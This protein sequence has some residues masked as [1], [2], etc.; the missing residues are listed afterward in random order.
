VFC[1]YAYLLL[2]NAYRSHEQLRA[3]ADQLVVADSKRRAAAVADLI[4][5]RRNATAD[6]AAAPEIASYLVNRSLGMSLRYG[7]N[8]NLFEIDERFRR[9]L[10]GVDLRGERIYRRIVLFDANDRPLVDVVGDGQKADPA[11]DHAG[12]LRI[13]TASGQIVV[14]APV[15]HKGNPSGTVSTVGDL[16]QVSRDLI[17]EANGPRREFLVTADGAELPAIGDPPPLDANLVLE[18]RRLPDNVPTQT[19]GLANRAALSAAGLVVKTS[20][21]GSPLSLV[22]LLSEEAAYGQ[23]SSK[24]FLYS[25][26]LFP[27]L[28]LFAAF[29]FERARRSRAALA[30]SQHRFRTIFDNIRDGIFIEDPVTRTVIEANPRAL[31]MYG[32]DAHEVVGLTAGALSEGVPPYGAPEWT[33]LVAK[34]VGGEPQFFSWRARRKNGALFW[35]EVSML[36]A[37]IDGHDRLIVVAHDIT[38]RKDQ[39]HEL[40]A[41]LTYQRQLNQRLEEAHNQLLQSE[42]MA[43]I[44]QLAAGVAHE[45]NNPIGYVASNLNSLQTYV[46]NLLK[47][48]AS[49]EQLEADIDHPATALAKT[50]AIRDAL[51]I[52]F[53]KDDIRSLCT[54]SARGL[55]RV[56]KIIRDLKDFSHVD[57]KA[58]WAEEDLHKG[59]ESTLNVIWN[60][61]KYKCEVRREYGQLPPV[62]C[63]IFQLNQVF[64]NLLINAAQAIETKGVITIRTGVAGD[65]VWIEVEDTGTGIPAANLKKL[66]DPF[67]TTKPVGKGTGLGLSVSYN[68]VMTHHG[69][70]DVVS[71]EGEGTTFRVT[72]PIKQPK[73]AEKAAPGV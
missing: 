23:V 7:L 50:H 54:E 58:E 41:A 35:V 15:V 36:Q 20:V 69:T 70:I 67:F 56:I 37:P 27:I 4:A 57:Q 39:E 24:V 21:P 47:L 25:A 32:Y 19:T 10:E 16:R 52:R 14:S 38:Q 44:G 30:E 29:M 51:D 18:L 5:E 66:F 17:S 55:D 48:I 72:L 40:L 64:M 68:I 33:A 11:P 2:A 26:S 63:L 43:S 8:A 13:D 53:L 62:E 6:L 12:A 9:Q 49:Y 45:I 73:N 22:T 60:E 59:L 46:D 65:N 1:A 3:E 34:A 31:A 61:L 71:R 28:V 42:K